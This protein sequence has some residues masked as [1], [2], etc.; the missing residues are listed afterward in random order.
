MVGT[1]L[2]LANLLRE[3]GVPVSTPEIMD[4]LSALALAPSYDAPTVRALLQAALIKDRDFSPLFEEAFEKAFSQP[5]AGVLPGRKAEAPAGTRGRE[6]NLAAGS[7]GPG[8][9]RGRGA[10]REEAFPGPGREMLSGQPQSSSGPIRDG[11]LAYR[12]GVRELITLPFIAAGRKQKEELIALIRQMARKLASRKGFKTRSGG[13]RLHFRKLW[14]NSMG[15]GGVPFSLAWQRRRL[16]KPRV[17]IICDLSK[18]MTPFLPFVLELVFSFAAAH[19]SVRVFGFVDSLE[20]IT[21]RIDPV[22]IK[23]SVESVCTGAR[24]VRRGLTDYGNAFRGFFKH[25]RNEITGKTTVIVV[26]DARNNSFASEARLLGEIGGMSSGVY[27]LNPESSHF[28]GMGDSYMKV[29][30]PYCKGVF[31]CRNLQQL[32]RF[33]DLLP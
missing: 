31:E 32:R 15:A 33:M 5:Y 16:N 10:A 18:S 20:E 14:R 28:W 23:R 11:A 6:V 8:S 2:K 3:G 21:R 22:D 12:P 26:G 7:G 27:W 29:Y 1:I 25:H 17:F 4:S 30:A 13:H 19:S 24:V 9:G